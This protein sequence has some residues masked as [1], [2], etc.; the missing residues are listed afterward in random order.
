MLYPERLGTITIN[1]G[2]VRFTVSP[3]SSTKPQIL[4]PKRYGD[5]SPLSLL[6]ASS[7]T[8]SPTPRVG[9]YLLWLS[10]L[11][12]VVI[13]SKCYIFLICEFL[14]FSSWRGSTVYYY[15]A[16]CSTKVTWQNFA[17]N[18][19]N[20][21]S[22]GSKQTAH[23]RSNKFVTVFIVL[24]LKRYWSVCKEFALVALVGVVA[25]QIHPAV[26]WLL[27]IAVSP[28]KNT[29]WMPHL[30][31][32]Y[33][34]ERRV[35]R[36]TRIPRISVFGHRSKAARIVSLTLDQSCSSTTVWVCEKKIYFINKKGIPL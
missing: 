1:G 24:T 31:L 27:V 36:R 8:H 23:Y 25:L 30:S 14:S 2:H 33:Q 3:L 17:D 35:I 13:G 34:T 15:S 20:L 16:T 18:Y 19:K 29:W 5:H 4:T 32:I 12:P 6:Y 7:P 28:S 26:N 11:L 22:N 9:H 10:L 21:G